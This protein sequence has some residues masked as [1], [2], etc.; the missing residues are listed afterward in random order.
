MDILRVL[1]ICLQILIGYN[2]VLPLLL[3][4]LYSVK[5]RKTFRNSGSPEADY[6][7]IVPAYRQLTYIH[8]VVASILKMNY[9]NYLIYIVA[10]D[11]DVSHLHF[12]DHRVI[13]LRP[14]KPLANHIASHFYA[15]H[16]FRRKHERL[17][18]IDSDNIVHP[19]YLTRISAVFDKGYHAAQGVRS[20]RNLNTTLA[21][22]DGARDIY[23]HFYDGKIL[24]QCGSSST[25]AGSG[26]AFTTELYKE[27]MEHSSVIGAGFD[28]VLQYEIVRSGHTIAFEE[29]AIVYDEKTSQSTQL[30]KQRAR[31]INTWF[32]FF[33][34]GFVLIGKGI[35]NR[36]WNQVLFGIVL[37]R[38]PLFIFLLSSLL[39]LFINL[40]VSP[41]SALIWAIALS[42][43]GAS[44]FIALLNNNTDKRIY[45][46]LTG[47]PRFIFYQVKSLLKMRKNQWYSVA[48]EHFSE[49]RK[50][51]VSPD[52]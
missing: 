16:R 27:C 19:D 33:Y 21:C 9:S 13:V 3:Y 48:T 45:Q 6:A 23:Y 14:E 46:S 32:S 20:P 29:S 36:S 24:F 31:W 22:L 35:R 34:F 41:T 11:C 42:L 49:T 30:V 4:V 12:D 26:M 47:I 25:L 38:P 28:K 2:L 18:I 7:I 10:D 5:K 8:S 43:F 17:T 40:F 1:W 50:D 52:R 15:I 39:C 44:F 37:L 51:A